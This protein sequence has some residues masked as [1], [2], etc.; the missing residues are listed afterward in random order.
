MNP[1]STATPYL[2]LAHSYKANNRINKALKA[3]KNGLNNFPNDHRFYS[4]LSEIEINRNKK[5]KAKGYADKGLELD[6]QN[7]TL[8][9]LKAET[10]NSH[11]ADE[12]LNMALS[13]NPLNPQTLTNKGWIALKNKKWDQA[14]QF[15]NSALQYDP[16]DHKAQYGLE[17]AHVSSIKWSRAF[18]S[19]IIYLYGS[20]SQ[21]LIGCT[22]GLS[23]GI[24]QLISNFEGN[25][26]EIQ[27]FSI[28]CVTIFLLFALPYFM[29]ALAL[30]KLFRVNKNIKRLL[31]QHAT[32]KWIQVYLYFVCLFA[33][34]ILQKVIKS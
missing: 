5:S 10:L 13:M 22:V 25:W 26:N 17:I 32:S 7:I 11:R 21:L 24:S 18:L 31:N 20:E 27:V 28:I 4:I 29:K 33:F 6:P 23:L 16:N 2:V 15:F 34:L 30:Q 3:S 1:K 8:L 19:Y 9:N 14:L 12:V